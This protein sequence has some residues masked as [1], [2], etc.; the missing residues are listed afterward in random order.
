MDEPPVALTNRDQLRTAAY[1]SSDLLADRAALYA[2]RVPPLDLRQWVAE[3]LPADPP[4]PTVDMGCGPGWYL[5]ATAQ[6][7]GRPAFGF[8]L[9]LGIVREAATSDDVAVGVADAQAVPVRAGT[10]G[11]VLLL[12]MLYH[13]P[14]PE[15]ALREARRVVHP[16]GVVAVLTN[17]TGH[18]GPMRAL[19]TAE[20]ELRG[21]VPIA[22]VERR[23]NDVTGRPLVDRVFARVE[24]LTLEATIEL[25]RAGPALAHLATGRHLYPGVD[26][27]QWHD[28]LSSV[29][30]RIERVIEQEGRWCTPTSSVFYLC[31][32]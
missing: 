31:H 1:A 26:D 12:H 19:L 17:R 5:P 2:A 23:F 22:S 29:D 4:G 25:D 6:K 21:I 8:D 13:V 9:S 14:D 27:S 11:A 24:E 32:A 16:D 18:L 20:L 10:A 3:Q 30:G 15:L 7:T 28:I